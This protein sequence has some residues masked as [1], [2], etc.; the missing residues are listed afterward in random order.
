MGG[1]GLG[2]EEGGR[3]G[4]CNWAA[5]YPLRVNDITCWMHTHTHTTVWDEAAEVVY[6]K[7]VQCSEATGRT[8]GYGFSGLRG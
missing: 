1:G 4:K 3:G 2:E 8:I 6:S 5:W 7:I